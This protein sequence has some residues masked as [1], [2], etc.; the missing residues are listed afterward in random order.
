MINYLLTYLKWLKLREIIPVDVTLPNMR[1]IK[2]KT[3]TKT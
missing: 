3:K 2:Q 1:R